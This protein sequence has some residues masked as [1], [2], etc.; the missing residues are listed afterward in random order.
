MIVT[1][2][3]EIPLAVRRMATAI[4]EAG[5]A[6]VASFLKR[7]VTAVVLRAPDGL[8]GETRFES[9][10]EV[11]LDLNIKADRNFIEDTVVIL[12]SGQIAEAEFW[13]KMAPLYVPFVDSHRSDDAEIQKLRSQFDLNH[14]QD[15]MF[16][17]YC[18]DKAR[19]IVLHE[20]SRA[21]IEEI[22]TQLSDS[23]SISGRELGEI[24][25]RHDVVQ[26]K[27]KFAPHPWQRRV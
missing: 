14:E 26:G 21:A 18:T 4:H 16:V 10:S 2:A 11:V 23:L 20:R 1:P 8:S 22:A 24:L 6:L 7:K 19:R 15:A 9:E 5:H 17:G 27:L 13:K 25:I 12:L 3:H